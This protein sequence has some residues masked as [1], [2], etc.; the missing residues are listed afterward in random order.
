MSRAFIQLQWRNHTLPELDT[1]I[2]KFGTFGSTSQ[3]HASHLP[4]LRPPPL[5]WPSPPTMLRQLVY[6]YLLFF[7]PLATSVGITADYV[8]V[9]AGTAGPVVAERL[10]ASPEIEVILLEAGPAFGEPN[11]AGEQSQFDLTLLRRPRDNI[12][13]TTDDWGYFSQPQP[14]KLRQKVERSWT[15]RAG[16][17]ANV[18]GGVS[19]L[20]TATQLSD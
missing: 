11:P 17:L 15:R 6:C 20:G 3:I 8:I 19:I 2:S 13:R 9:G 10:S 5:L 12:Q 1:R 4:S 18:N 7:I 16:G 14:G